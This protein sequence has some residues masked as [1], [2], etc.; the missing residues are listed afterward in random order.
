MRWTPFATPI[1]L[2]TCMFAAPALAADDPQ[3]PL[4]DPLN[5]GMWDYHQVNL[6]GDPAEIQFDDRVRVLA[7]ASAEDSLNVP[8]LVDATALENVEKIVVTA[9]YGPIPHI[10][11]FYPKEAD[12]KLALR[13]KIDQGTAIRASVQTKDGAWHIGGT[14][15]DAAGGG[16]TAPAHAYANAN[17]EEEMGKIN[18]RVWTDTGRVRFVVDHPMDT[19]LAG[20]IPVFIITDLKLTSEDGTEMAH[21]ELHEPV[22]EDPAFTLYFDPEEVQTAMALTGRDNNG[23]EIDGLLS[24]GW[25][26]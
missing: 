2:A 26:N 11:T 4:N 10:L 7:P 18:G 9:D 14:Y 16:C 3:V 19:G 24:T 25:T 5:S 8:L 22:N 17:W 1:V 12:A 6:L 13:F 15:I 23:N 21:I 20:D